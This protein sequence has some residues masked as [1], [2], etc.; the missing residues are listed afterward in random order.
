MSP[1]P[2]DWRPE[3]AAIEAV[4]ITAAEPVSSQLL[5]ELLELPV[6][7]IDQLC[8]VMAECYE[9]DERG[10]E[11]AHVGGGYRFQSHPAYR[12]YVERFILDDMPSKLSPAALETLAIV[13]YKQPISRGQ[14]AQIRGVNADGVIRLLSQR[15]Y[16]E[17]VGRD[18]GPGQAILFGTSRLFLERLGLYS[19]DDLP[20]LEDFVPD[21]STV[22]LLE[23]VLRPGP[24]E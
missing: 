20:P 13:A 19:L 14:I 3:A 9:E 6:E 16:V 11:L 1:L 4:I 17:S 22:E 8:Q 23:Q 7:R 5:S 12:G 24:D 18:D 15:G 2:V 21:V 10:F